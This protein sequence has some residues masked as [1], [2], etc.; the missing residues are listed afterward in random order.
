M[1]Y[2][3]VKE[4]AEKWNLSTRRIQ[5]LCTNGQVPGAMKFGREWAI[6]NECEKPV[7]ARIKSGK[8]IKSQKMDTNVDILE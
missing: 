1:D 5:T 6:P 2:M 8:Y 7:D 3:T 4:A